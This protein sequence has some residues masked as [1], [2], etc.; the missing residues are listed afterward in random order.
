MAK[1]F[2][3]TDKYKKRFFRGLP[4]QYKLLWDYLYHDCDHAGVWIVDF[5]IAQIYL[6][7]DA[8]IN[9]EEAL[10]LFNEGELRIIEIKKGKY[11]F[12]PSFLEFQYGPQ[13][14]KKNNI[15]ASIEKILKKHDLFQYLNMEIVEEGTTKSA[16][17]K[18][19]SSKVKDRIFL[20]YDMTCQYCQ[21]KKRKEE[22][23]VDHI[24]SLEKGGDSEDKNLT[25]ACIR[26]NSYK[27]D[28]DPDDF[29]NRSHNF[30]NPT[31]ELKEAIKILKGGI[32]TLEEGR[33]K[34]KEQDKDKDKE[35]NIPFEDFWNTYDYKQDI[36]RCR[37]YWTGKTKL[38]NG[39][40]IKDSDRT[41]IMEVLPAYIRS[42]PDKNYRKHPATYLYNS[43][44]L[45]EVVPNGT[46]KKRSFERPVFD[47]DEGEELPID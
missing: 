28:L 25:C 34:D 31:V 26:C 6:G 8:P 21:D 37:R 27:S 1:R 30:L 23:V 17:R 2:T 3:D 14:S 22:L 24:I 13:I 47:Y 42:A 5:E 16:L 35:I 9:K 38:K 4:C 39:K 11:W 44:W 40:K 10:R 18:R 43:A 15:Y 29:I 46:S 36:D 41:K 7:K 20:S 33:D 45:D 19:I 32:S 12:I